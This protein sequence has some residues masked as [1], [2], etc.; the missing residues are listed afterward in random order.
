MKQVRNE[1]LNMEEL[2]SS[3]GFYFLFILVFL[4]KI[5]LKWAQSHKSSNLNIAL[6]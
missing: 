5:N 1:K 6:K 4:T 3:L 2:L